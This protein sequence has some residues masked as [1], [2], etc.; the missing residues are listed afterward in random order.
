MKR[1]RGSW[2]ASVTVLAVSGLA[3][4]AAQAQGPYA[5]VNGKTL[6]ASEG[7]TIKASIGET[8]ELESPTLSQKIRCTGVGFLGYCVR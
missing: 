4:S 8:F 1:I 5:K 3:V 6:K 7:R 2:L